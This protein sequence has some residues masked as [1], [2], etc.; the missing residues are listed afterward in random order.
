MVA[1]PCSG[2]PQTPS[3]WNYGHSSRRVPV[4]GM[5]RPGGGIGKGVFARRRSG[6]RPRQLHD[7]RCP[8]CIPSRG[9]IPESP[10]LLFRRTSRASGTNSPQFRAEPDSPPSARQVA[11]LEAARSSRAGRARKHSPV[12]RLAR[13]GFSVTESGSLG[14]PSGSPLVEDAVVC[15]AGRSSRDGQDPPRSAESHDH[16]RT[17]TVFTL[18]RIIWSG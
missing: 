3:S 11:D 13:R 8:L 5:P 6:P 1:A 2:D 18:G 4:R 9:R 14:E 15:G 12:E 10:P 7:Q 17:Q 16:D